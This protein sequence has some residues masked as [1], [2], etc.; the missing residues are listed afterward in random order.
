MSGNGG[1]AGESKQVS[2]EQE[3]EQRR[4]VGGRERRN[5]YDGLEHG[6]ANYLSLLLPLLPHLPS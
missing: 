6:R 1:R 3:A 4:V 5:K 2:G